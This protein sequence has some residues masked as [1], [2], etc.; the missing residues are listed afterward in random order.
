MASIGQIR[1]AVKDLVR[2]HYPESYFYH[3]IPE[4]F[5]TPSFILTF[6]PE[7]KSGKAETMG[8]GWVCY[9]MLLDVLMDYSESEMDQPELDT[10]FDYN[11]PHSLP[12][13]FQ[14]NEDLGLSDT[15]V[16]FEGFRGYGGAYRS[17]GVQATGVQLLL[18]VETNPRK[19]A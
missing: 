7:R 3:Y 16:F 17:A 10:H 19:V 8:A 13:L 12:N 4:T 5:E 1:E 2:A 14:S 18:R 11:N 15:V 6:D 9:S